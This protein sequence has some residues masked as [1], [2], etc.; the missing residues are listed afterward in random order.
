[1]F[2]IMYE[3]MTHGTSKVGKNIRY[4]LIDLLNFLVCLF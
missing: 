3:N 2:F 1:M 4:V